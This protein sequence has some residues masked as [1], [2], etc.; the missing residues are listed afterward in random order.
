[1]GRERKRGAIEDLVRLIKGRPGTLRVA[2]GDADMAFFVRRDARR[3]YGARHRR[4]ANFVAAM[5]HPLNRP[6]ID[7][8]RRVVT[9]GHALLH[10][11]IAVGLETS[12]RNPFA[13]V[14]A[15]PGGG[16]PYG[17]A[18]PD[19]YHDLY[20]KSNYTGKGIFDVEAYAALLDGRFPENAILSHD[21][22]EG[23]YLR[24]GF[25]GDIEF[26]DGFPGSVRSYF[27][28]EHRWVRGDWQ[29]L[30]WLFPRVRTGTGTSAT[31]WT[32]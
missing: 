32:A 21:M 30:P 29:L 10:P 28:R 9:A 4:C 7:S 5:E 26:L 3:R 14:Y 18:V 11:R 31:R 17:G 19:L 1:M 23:G 27:E 22:I 12:S 16:D 13:A 25:A 20:G 8:S 15:G 24:A 6:V 2:E